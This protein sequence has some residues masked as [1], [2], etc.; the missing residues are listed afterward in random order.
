MVLRNLASRDRSFRV[1]VSWDDNLGRSLMSLR[2]DM[3]RFFQDV[4]GDDFPTTLRSGGTLF[5][6][7]DIME[8]DRDF[9]IKAELLDMDPE[10]IDVSINDGNL[11]IQGE[12]KEEKEDTGDKGNYLR[13]EISYGAFSRIIPLPESASIDEAQASFDKGFLT[14]SVPK[15][16]ESQGKLRKLKINR[17]NQNKEESRVRH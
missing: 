6:A 10:N 16:A 12:R 14:V 9:I 8:S 15:K 1:P 2:D 13:R 17:Q 4:W 7:V 11:C 5:P 3:S